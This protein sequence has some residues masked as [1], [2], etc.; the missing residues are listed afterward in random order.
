MKSNLSSVFCAQMLGFS[1]KYAQSTLTALSIPWSWIQE[2]LIHE[3]CIYL[4]TRL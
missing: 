4:G 1:S 2:K 3:F